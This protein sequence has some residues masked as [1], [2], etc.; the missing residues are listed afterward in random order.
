MEKAPSSKSYPQ[1][2]DSK[3]QTPYLFFNECGSVRIWSGCSALE[4]KSVN[5]LATVPHCFQSLNPIR[6][7]VKIRVPFWVPLNIRCR[8]ILGTQKG[9]IIL[10]TTHTLN[11]EARTLLVRVR[12]LPECRLRP[13]PGQLPTWVFI[14]QGSGFRVTRVLLY[15]TKVKV[16]C[17][18]GFCI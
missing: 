8:T 9:T 4:T 10:T 17:S 7:V 16:G 5:P 11:H 6:V 14:V 1:T 12:R 15:H 2:V 18:K 13:R 3:T